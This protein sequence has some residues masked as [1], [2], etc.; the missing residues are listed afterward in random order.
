M[1]VLMIGI[2]AIMVAGCPKLSE[3][4]RLLRDTRFGSDRGKAVP[5]KYENRLYPVVYGQRWSELHISIRGPDGS[6][7]TLADEETADKIA[8]G[9][10]VIMGC[11]AKQP[12][13][14]LPVKKL[15]DGAFAYAAR[16]GGRPGDPAGA[17]V[18]YDG[19]EDFFSGEVAQKLR[20][21]YLELENVAIVK[22]IDGSPADLET[23]QKAVGNYAANY[24]GLDKLQTFRFRVPPSDELILLDQKFAH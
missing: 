15:M 20:V 9:A 8:E 16:C 24:L 6:A 21:T 19:Y 10:L 5:F 2:V 1:R 23:V 12:A 4:D 7:M 18:E 3:Q 11:P 22:T 13:H 14:L 17:S